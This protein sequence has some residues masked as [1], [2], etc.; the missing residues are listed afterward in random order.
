LSAWFVSGKAYAYMALKIILTSIL[1]EYVVCADGTIE[2][3]AL[4]A[5]ISVRTKNKQYPIRI[6]KRK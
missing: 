4:K 6:E 2:D 3:I 5:D 1:K